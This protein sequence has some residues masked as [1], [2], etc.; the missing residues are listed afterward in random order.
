MGKG[1]MELTWFPYVFVGAAI[2]A[3]TITV[4][5]CRR[6]VIDAFNS[7][8][9]VLDRILSKDNN[10]RLEIT[11]DD[12]ISKLTHKANRVVDMCISDM[13]QSKEEKETIQGFISDMSH[14]MKTPLSSITMYA[15]L[16]IESNLSAEEQQEFLTRLKV[17]TEKLQWMMDSLIKMSRLEVGAIQ[18]TP[19]EAGIKQTISESIGGVVA[20]AAK[21]N[22]NITV[23][24][25]DDVALYHDRKLTREA[26][27][28]ILENAV[29]YSPVNGSIEVSIERLSLYTKITITD[30]G[31]GI[32]K[33][34]FNLIYKRFYR[35]K[36]AKNYEGAG[37]GL[38]LATLIMEKQGGYIMVDAKPFEFTSF[39][40]FLQNCKK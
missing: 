12:R 8:D 6:Y 36:N 29:K 9:K 25:F 5:Y 37:L 23:S 28:N 39:S 18:L 19:V 4:L 15:D 27:N 2:L 10:L 33:S 1:V 14:Q 20:I 17:G 7:I 11:E 22:I 38:Y 30:H 40:L 32:D 35:G 21:K 13:A 16:L 26:L 31:I 24:S 3:L 34:D